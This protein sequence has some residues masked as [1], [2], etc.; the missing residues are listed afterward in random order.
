MCIPSLFFL[1]AEQYSI[2]WMYQNLMIHSPVNGHLGCF[3]IFLFLFFYFNK[4]A[5]DIR[6]YVFVWTHQIFFARINI[7]NIKGF[8]KG[9]KFSCQRREAGNGNE[10]SRLD[11]RQT[12]VVETV[13]ICHKNTF[14]LLVYRNNV[15][16]MRL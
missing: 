6:V 14:Q 10:G 13:T 4:T 15:R 5:M 8:R 12:G 1:I 9:H 11:I 7:R 2:V 3:Q 16:N